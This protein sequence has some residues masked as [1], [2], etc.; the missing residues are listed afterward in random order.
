MRIHGVTFGSLNLLEEV[1]H[2]HNILFFTVLRVCEDFRAKEFHIRATADTVPHKSWAGE[3]HTKAQSRLGHHSSLWSCLNRNLLLNES[4]K[5]FYK[6]STATNGL[7]LCLQERLSFIAWTHTGM[8]SF[9]DSW[10][11]HCPCLIYLEGLKL[12]NMMGLIEVKGKVF[13]WFL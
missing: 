10:V 5:Y 2:K 13:D 7:Q 12:G 8:L 4:W 9:V 6:S 3:T 11:L 1:W